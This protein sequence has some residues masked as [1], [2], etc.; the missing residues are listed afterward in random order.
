ML[1]PLAIGL[2]VQ[3]RYD[4]TAACV[5]PPLDWISNVSLI[6]LIVLITVVNFDKILQVFMS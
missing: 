4:V 5:K 1:L 2:F 3:A 6:L